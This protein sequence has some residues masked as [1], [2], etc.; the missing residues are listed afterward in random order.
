MEAAG[1]DV[2]A[3]VS[4]IGLPINVIPCEDNV[5]GKIRHTRINSYGLLLLD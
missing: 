4:K 2:F 5:Y 3:T 1:I